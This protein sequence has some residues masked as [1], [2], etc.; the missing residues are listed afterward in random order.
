[1]NVFILNIDTALETATV[2]LSKGP[3]L[4]GFFTTAEQKEHATMLHPGIKKLLGE[5]H[6]KMQDLN[7]VAVTAGPGSYTGLRVGMATAKGLC[8][9][10]NIPFITIGTLELMAIN[11]ASYLTISDELLCPMIDAR[12]MEVFTA[13]FDRN[14]QVYKNARALI[15][16]KDSF[17]EELISNQIIFFGNGASKFENLQPG[18][19]STFKSIPLMPEIMAGCSYKKYLQCDF[20]NLPYSQPLYIKDF[21]TISPTEKRSL[22]D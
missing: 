7:A 4:I 14:A 10:L 20:S 17:R 12:R 19:N 13:L 5:H 3:D 11:A 16:S 18:P 2:S 21:H 6:V 22:P 9:A 8:Y 1:M 15:L